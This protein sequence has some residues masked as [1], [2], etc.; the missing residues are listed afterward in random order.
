[1][2]K[3]G[4]KAIEEQHAPPLPRRTEDIFKES[5]IFLIGL[6]HARKHGMESEYVQWFLDDYKTSH[7]AQ[8]ASWY[9]FREWD[10]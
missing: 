5:Q 3:M 10:L 2:S 4:A 9:A 6:D 1:M 8:Q 7:N